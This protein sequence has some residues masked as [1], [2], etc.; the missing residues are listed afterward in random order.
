MDSSTGKLAHRS[1]KR[2][3]RKDAHKDT[4]VSKEH[5]VEWIIEA[6]QQVGGYGNEFSSRDLFKLRE[7][8]DKGIVSSHCKVGW[9]RK[10]GKG[11][12]RV[13]KGDLNSLAMLRHD[14]TFPRVDGGG[15]LLLS[16]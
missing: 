14:F 4:N 7:S 15:G 3:G 13:V 16:P 5:V 2:Q 9:H 8:I 6:R 12:R 1:R 10:E 11:S